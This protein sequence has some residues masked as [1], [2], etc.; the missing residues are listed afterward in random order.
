MASLIKGK[1]AGRERE[2]GRGSFKL[3]RKKEGRP[4]DARSKNSEGNAKSL[5]RGE[6]MQEIPKEGFPPSRKRLERETEED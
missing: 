2:R 6:E 5:A 1:G 3:M 4:L